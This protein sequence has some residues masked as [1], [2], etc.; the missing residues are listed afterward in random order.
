[1]FL[2]FC[3]CLSVCLSKS[4]GRIAM[5]FFAR[6][7]CVTSNRDYTLEAMHITVRIQ[8]FLRRNS[9][10]RIGAI[11]RILLVTQEVVD[12]FWWKCLKV[13]CLIVNKLD[14]F[15]CWS[16]S[17]NYQKHLYHCEIGATVRMRILPIILLPWRKY[18]ISEVQMLHVET[19]S[20]RWVFWLL[21]FLGYFI[22]SV[23]R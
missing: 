18:A 6:V 22:F 23:I 13:G 1:M 8:D 7:D 17:R 15:W 3:I 5:I 12:A 4:C 19:Y 21:Y 16:E 11:Q 20:A 14:R 2:P 10:C 9:R